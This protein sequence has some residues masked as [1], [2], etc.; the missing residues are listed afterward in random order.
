M[1]TPSLPPGSLFGNRFLI[2]RL[3]GQGGMGTVYQATDQYSGTPVALKL[4][5]D[6]GHP[7]ELER[8]Q[9]EALLLAE[10]R[11]PGIVS[12][13]S[14][15]QTPD[16]LRYLVMEWLAGHD[17]AQ[18]LQRGPLSLTDSLRLLLRIAQS[19]ATAHDRGI[20]HRERRQKNRNRSL[21]SH[22]AIHAQRPDAGCAICAQRLL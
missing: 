17:L 1:G 14:H 12:H 9:R 8:F 21:P 18:H 15:G 2:A 13:I 16:G 20:I 19:L 10:L 6:G 7:E 3:A 5:Q 22:K 4:L 11:H